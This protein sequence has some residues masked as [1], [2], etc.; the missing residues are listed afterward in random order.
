M[1]RLLR[2]P[3]FLELY[4]ISRT[5][6]YREVGAGRLMLSKIGNA[7]RIAAEDA[8]D[9]AAALPKWDAVH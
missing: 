3:E 4:S 1:K 7:S 8:E 2:I 9:W 5:A 6:L